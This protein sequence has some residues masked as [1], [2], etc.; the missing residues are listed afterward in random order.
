[1]CPPA[2]GFGYK[3][4][5]LSLRRRYRYEWL[6]LVLV[7]LSALTIVNVANP[8]DTTRYELTRHIVLY[9]TLTIERDIFDRAVYGGRT[10]SDKAPGMSFLAIPAYAVERA[11]GVAR[12]PR[13]WTGKGD[14]S[15]W[16]IRVATS[17][18]L[19]LLAGLLVGRAAEALVEGTGAATFAVFGT[20]TLAAPL[21]PTLFEHDAAAFFAL[22]GFLLAWRQSRPL[23]LVAAGIVLGTGVLFQYAVGTIAIVVAIYVAAR[24]R[25]RVGWFVLG[26]LLPALALGAYNRSAFGSPFHLSYRYVAN[27]YSELQH[28]GFFGI[29]IP[30]LS[31]LSEVLVGD[32]GLLLLSPVLVA[33]AIGLCLMWRHGYR[34][35][36]AVAATVSVVFVLADA[37]Y[38]I[39]YGGNSPGPRFAVPALPFLALGL[40]FALARFPKTTLALAAVSC[41]LT[42][43]D[44]L[45]WG[46]R[47]E[48][49]A[50]YPGSGFSDLTTTVWGRA[51][52]D[53]IQGGGL[54]GL[55]ALG[56]VGTGAWVVLRRS[57]VAADALPSA[58]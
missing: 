53:R 1:V 14:L 46:L 32:R 42:S 45:T 4:I 5:G 38:F 58:P 48:G 21:A 24:E 30:R 54:V 51:G 19:F 7:V 36:A 20:A 39:P 56:A 50:W 26:G 22:A 8:Q 27:R 10:Y 47:R 40:P 29:G 13:D 41:V 37:A 12:A 55:A 25:G 31:G 18:L 15:L 6:V 23:L 34:G 52:L 11:L 44:S 28:G 9:H 33:A 16:G 57:R 3:S 35:E 17:G 43:I 49:D 2:G